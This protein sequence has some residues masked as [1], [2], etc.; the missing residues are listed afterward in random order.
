MVLVIDD[1]PQT[2]IILKN[3]FQSEDVKVVK[4]DRGQKGLDEARQDQAGP[5]RSGLADAGDERL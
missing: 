4:A 1:A 3:S 2:L 5:H